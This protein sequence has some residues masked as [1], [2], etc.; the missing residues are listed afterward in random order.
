MEL[1]IQE[2]L[3][4]LRVERGL[5]L[6]QL[7]EETHLSKSALGSYEGDNLKDIS[8]H[9]LIQLAKVY[10]VTVDYLLGRSKT[11]N[12]PNADLADLRLSDDMIE[13]L[14]SG[15][16]DTSLLCELAVHPDF[17]RLMADLEIYVNG[18]AV[19]QVQSANAIVDAM[20]A[21]IMKQYNPGLTD[22]QLRQLVTAHIDDDS[23]CRYVI[24]QDIN[25]IALDLREA[26][27]DDFFSVPED[28]PLEDFLQ[29]VDEAA[30]PDSDPEQAALAFIC[31]RLKLNLKKL[32]EEEKKWLKKIA[33][34]S[35]LLK[36]PNPQRGKSKISTEKRCL[37]VL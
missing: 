4:D 5:T 7:A 14:K 19:K 34:K 10:E 8:H 11:K 27:K 29:T 2:R 33:Q 26:H 25:K 18:T 37:D 1:S 9:A 28:N 22:P 24:Q 12:H 20:S 35:D 21:T 36:N 16:V 32:S 31:K 30:S 6:E 3:K 17:P 15:R 23:F 13:L